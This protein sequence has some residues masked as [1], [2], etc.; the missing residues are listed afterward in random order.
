[1]RRI[2]LPLRIVIAALFVFACNA[3]ILADGVVIKLT[4]KSDKEVTLSD[5][6]AFSAQGQKQT[7]LAPGD[8]SDDIKVGPGGEQLLDLDFRPTSYI[9][10]TKEGNS[11]PESK[12]FNVNL[13]TPTKVPLLKMRI[14]EQRCF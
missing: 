4:N 14:T 9:V 10:S 11:E 5:F 8:D 3:E 12:V 2:Q 13:V 7:R 6:Y 1:M